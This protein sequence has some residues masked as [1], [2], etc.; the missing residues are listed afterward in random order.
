MK[1]IISTISFLTILSLSVLAQNQLPN[2]R[3]GAAV[4]HYNDTA[5]YIYGGVV[6]DNSKSNNTTSTNDL[7]HYNPSNNT[8]TKITPSGDELP[9]AC[10][11][12]MAYDHNT[13]KMIVLGGLRTV[14]DNAFYT[15]DPQAY[16]VSKKTQQ[17]YSQRRCISGSYTGGEKWLLS[18][19]QLAD[20][21]ASS[22]VYEYNA[23]TLIFTQ[24][25]DIP[26]GTALY[27]HT[28]ISDTLNN[29]VYIFG[30]LN[31]SGTNN[32][33]CYEFNTQNNS[34]N[35]GPNIQN[36]PQ[37]EW[38]AFAATGSTL[39][40]NETFIIG[41][42]KY[43]A[44]KSTNSI[45]FSTNLY[46]VKLVNGNLVGKLITTN[47]PPI[48]DGVGWCS[49]EAN[50]DTVFYMFGGISSITMTGDT[51]YT[52][53]FYRY[54]QTTQLIQQY[55]TTQQTWGGIISSINETE[56]S[57]NI[58]LRVYPNPATNEI[59]IAVPNN[60]RIES[61]KIYNQNGLLVKQIT[62]ID[63]T[64]VNISDLYTGVYFIRIDTE[65]NRYLS[66]LIKKQ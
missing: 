32:F 18:G 63:K 49:L 36:Y 33:S 26:Q 41:G 43:S 46:T 45:A 35:F 21:T 19:G 34:W 61:I 52:N 53:N 22:A 62:N 30:G 1:Q 11:A 57:E 47:L 40:D 15:F 23:S 39:L 38:S 8:F 14:N 54:N 60:E 58:N 65:K 59:I 12:F 3:Y 48:I 66:K 56:F 51:T 5:V 10:G 4:V 42:Q 25:S 28:S 37:N 29:K 44:K 2:P 50:N 64:N 13:G 16:I 6:Q 7:Y 27:G 55:D 9:A 17:L 20:G 31:G 24:K